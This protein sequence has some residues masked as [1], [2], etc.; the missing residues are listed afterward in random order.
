MAQIMSKRLLKIL[1]R[2][3]LI[4]VE[5]MFVSQLH[6]LESGICKWVILIA[7]KEA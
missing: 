2:R 6:N 3:L 7:I 1:Y 4:S 5:R